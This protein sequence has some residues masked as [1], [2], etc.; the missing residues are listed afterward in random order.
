M[1][2]STLTFEVA[3][4]NM[5][6]FENR[7][8]WL[9]QTAHFEWQTHGYVVSN[10]QEQVNYE[11]IHEIVSTLNRAQNAKQELT[12][13]VIHLHYLWW[14]RWVLTIESNR[15]RVDT[16]RYFYLYNFP[17][18]R[19]QKVTILSL[20]D[21]KWTMGLP[22]NQIKKVEEKLRIYDKLFIEIS[23]LQQILDKFAP[24]YEVKE[25]SRKW[26]LVPIIP[27]KLYVNL[28]STQTKIL[29]STTIL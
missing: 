18:I 24:K 21:I 26:L 14:I 25:L 8:Q 19:S 15:R 22:I 29:L 23:L 4:Q 28:L 17:V 27:W 6:F 5:A 2:I 7:I 12:F 1:P 11:D 16:N 13:D 10:F 20:L 3:K 9:L